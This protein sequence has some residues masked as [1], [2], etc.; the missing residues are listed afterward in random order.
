VAKQDYYDTIGENGY[1]PDDSQ[2]V[3][4]TFAASSN[5]SLSSIKL[6]LDRVE[7]MTSITVQLQATTDGAP[8]GTDLASKTVAGS[9]IPTTA[10]WVEFTFTTPVSVTEGVVY[11]IVLSVVGAGGW[12]D[13]YY[14]YPADYA[15]GTDWWFNA[16]AEEWQIYDPDVDFM[17]ETYGE[18]GSIYIDLAGTVSGAGTITGV[19]TKK[20]TNNNTATKSR[21]VAAGSNQIWI[22]DI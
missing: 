16:D 2:A 14:P 20:F 9:A 22:E 8:N 21:L 12:I 18:G 10:A 3:A 4:Q 7:S 13:W 17:F 5:Y 19:L 1:S 6:Y 15:G 11:A